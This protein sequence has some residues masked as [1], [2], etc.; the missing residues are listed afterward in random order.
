MR[1]PIGFTFR[2]GTT[3]YTS[4]Y[5]M[6]NGRLQFGNVTCGYGT[7]AI[8][9]P[10]TY[11]YGYPDASMNATM[12]IFGVDLD[13]TN[14]VDVPN[15][16]SASQKTPCASSAAC[17]VSFSTIGSPGS[18]QFV[19]TWK[20]V[21]EWVSASNTSGSF[22]LQII[23][24]EDGSFIYQYGSIVHGGT[25]T[26][27]IGWQL[28]TSDYK[29]LNFGASAEPPPNTAIVFYAQAAVA[30][31]RFDDGAWVAGQAGQVI[32]S[33][34]NGLHG[35]AIG[36]AQEISAGKLCRAADIPANSSGAQVDAIKMLDLLTPGF[37]LRGAGTVAFWYKANAN[38][39][40]GQTAQLLDA[41]AVNG[42]WFYLTRSATGT[43]YF[44]VKD[45]TGVLRSVETPVQ[46]VSAGTWVHIA[47]SW[48][49]NGD[50]AANKDFLNISVN[51]GTPT[52]SSFTSNGT[53]TTQAGALYLG[54][55]P[56]GVADT[57]G[58]VNSAD[59][60]VDEAQVYN[61]VLTPAQ[62][63]AI[64]TATRTCPVFALDHFEIQ[65]AS[66]SGLTCT[67]STV[68]IRACSNASCSTLY[69]AGVSA[70]VS[71]TGGPTP[72]FDSATGNG[73]GAAFS[74]PIGSSSVT[75]GFQVVSPGSSVL[76]ITGSSVSPSSVATCNFGAPSCTFTTADSGFLF[77]VPNHVSDL[78]QTVSITAV[79]K[80]D[81]AALCVPAFASVTKSIG[82]TCAYLNPSSGTLPVRVGA[83]ALNAANNAGQACDATGQA[84][85]LAF[86]AAGTAS[87]S[88]R[89]ADAGQV[90]LDARY[91]GS[92]SDAGLVMTG[93][94]SFVAAPASFAISGVTAAPIRA[95]TAFGASVT[96]LNS[97]GATTP[98]FGRESAP[99]GVTIAF[100]R[101]QPTGAGASNGTFTGSLG[102]FSAGVA[103]T[104]NLVWSEVGRGDLTATLTGA[105]YLGS[106]FGATGTTG[107]GGAVGRFIPHHF[108]VVVTPACGAFTYAG[109]PFSVRVTAKNGL[110]TPGT[111]LNY[112]GSTA[113]AP[114]FAQATTLADAPSLGLGS[115]GASGAIAA[116]AFTA[117]VANTA[118]PAYSFTAKLTAA[119]TLGVRAT[120]VDGTSSAGW[121]EGTT[122]LRSGRLRLSN[123]F[124][125]E[126]A[127]LQLAVQ[128]Q[129]WSG[130]AWVA[131]GAD[132][133][134]AVPAAAV[135]RSNYLDGRGTAGATWTTNPGAIAIV[136][137]AG[138][139]TLSA[140]NPAATGSVDLALNLGAAAADQSCLAS[141]PA[142]TGAGLP[143]L[144]AQ[145]GSCSAA[146]DRD[147][148][149]RAT[150]GIYAPETRKLL[151]VREIF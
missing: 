119:Q 118:T 88:V 58:S 46:A 126:K 57:R 27:Q 30:S 124:G 96:A 111:T 21:P 12:K 106:G 5:I 115:F 54:D 29:V 72:T 6:S 103:V 70:T 60:V 76:G 53:V 94:S 108:D 67:P 16:P 132:S 144:R 136:G 35:A 23:L 66:G 113:T 11:P 42:E 120:D 78:A 63:A 47:V 52:V 56:L 40:S 89:Y 133:C 116:S 69:T 14:L 7:N 93:S 19:V 13:P 109:Q 137:G 146:W 39:N 33:S 86:N 32:D 81:N 102:A 140:P 8:G 10:Q 64:M 75:K 95:G 4:A 148:A 98:N 25:G 135:A 151:H 31:Y 84:H 79:R 139:L 147:P 134:T 82:F 55:N 92:G 125:S 71:A 91:T 85:S 90:R 122:G 18:R 107:N 37:N 9:P 149:A 49:F 22:D 100:V 28:S 99:Q 61:Y 127:P 142:T 1:I 3:N 130:N 44:A 74:I 128:A 114:N 121:A 41:T 110:A 150:F 129:Y 104:T 97:S 68:T 48:E 83:S 50:A 105:N 15:Y 143:W 24:N 34:A 138:T 80:A 45:S 141:H 38:W 73:V 77:S 87:I 112:D 62:L 117:G 145:Q 65:H 101:A 51:G 131:N 2:Y 123:A 43:L 26:A 20:N 59:G 17:Y 36:G